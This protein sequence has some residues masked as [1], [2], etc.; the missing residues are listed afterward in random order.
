MAGRLDIRPLREDDLPAAWTCHRAAFARFNGIAEP[1]KFR[2]GASIIEPRW[3]AWPEA[4]FAATIDGALAGVAVMMNW[5]SVCILGPVA[6]HPD[7]WGQGIARAL[8]EP[9][10]AAIEAGSFAFTGLYTHAQSPMHIRLYEA[11]E[12]GIGRLTAIL[13]KPISAAAPIAGI[14][15]LSALSGDSRA[16]R[17]EGARLVA[18]S[19]FPGLDLTGEIEVLMA[20][21]AGDVLFVMEGSQVAGVALCHHGPGSEAS[22]G[23]V[24]V[25]VAAAETGSHAPATFARLLDACE[26]YAA[27]VGATRVVAGTN[28][29]RSEAYRLMRQAGFRADIT[30]IAMLRPATEGYNLPHIFAI[31]D[32]R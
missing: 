1:E 27:D 20:N 14:E 2:P 6:V 8:M 30:G 3:R 23:Q 32:W 11:Y 29:G 21:I 9:L 10:I 18:D 12:F 31:D 19:V 25:K 16:A 4:G 22:E 13:S 5:G 7:H 17:I 28:T 26:A 24:L 15:R